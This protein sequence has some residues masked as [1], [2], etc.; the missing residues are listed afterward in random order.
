M[1][2][3]VPAIAALA[4]LLTASP[5]LGQ[6]LIHPT[7]DVAVDYQAS[8]RSDASDPM[9]SGL[10]RMFWTG[11]GAQARVELSGMPIWGIVNFARDR[12]TVVFSFQHGYAQMPLDREGIPG[13]SVPR[14]ATMTRIGTGTV[15]GLG[16]TVWRVQWRG[17][18][19]TACITTGG[20]VL[21]AKGQTGRGGGSGSLRA[22]R[23]EYG[24]QPA[25]LFTPPAGFR[26]IDLPHI[27]LGPAGPHQP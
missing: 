15:V 13:L 21:R 3:A 20:L 19:G 2:S 17:D 1:R 24:P 9:Q 11:H 26:R 23:V 12:L 22:V 27:G 7:R 25:G 16:C 6:P 5:A 8:G 14:D 4:A 18:Q 10:V